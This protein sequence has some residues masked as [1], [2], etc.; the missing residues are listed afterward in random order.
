M[1]IDN[2]NEALRIHAAG[3][4]WSIFLT[5]LSDLLKGKRDE[6]VELLL[7]RSQLPHLPR[8]KEKVDRC[9]EKFR[10]NAIVNGHLGR[11]RPVTSEII[12]QGDRCGVRVKLRE[13]VALGFG[14]RELMEVDGR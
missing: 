4:G 7:D 3:V 9:L 8:L 12:D 2:S 6:A 11:F 13:T 14:K 1:D 10:L 5:D